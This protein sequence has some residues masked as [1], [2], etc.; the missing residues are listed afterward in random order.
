MFSEDDCP[1]CHGKRLNDTALSVKVGGKNIWDVTC[2][3]IGSAAHYFDTLLNDLDQK[4]IEIAGVALNEINNRLSFLFD[5]GLHYITLNR[6]AGTLSGGEAQRIRLA[7]QV[8]QQLVG[9]LYVL[10]EPT[11]SLHFDDINRLLQVLNK[12]VDKGNT[13]LIIEHQ[14]DV[15]KFSD[16]IIDLGPEGGDGGGQ[17]LFE[18]TPEKMVQHKTSHTARLL[19]AEMN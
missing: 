11:T 9:A 2:L 3:N 6:K 14:L 19:K 10:D 18:G 1:K 16:W 12:L 17:I 7:S 8:G 15:I 4:K 13:V 5:V